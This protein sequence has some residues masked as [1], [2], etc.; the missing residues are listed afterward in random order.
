MYKSGMRALPR[1]ETGC[2]APP[3]TVKIGKI[4]GAERGKVGFNQL[5]FVQAIT[6]KESRSF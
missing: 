2:T 4:C 1:G 3:H 6:R 5:K